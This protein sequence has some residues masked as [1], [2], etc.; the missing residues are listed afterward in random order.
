MMTGGCSTVGDAVFVDLGQGRNLIGLVAH[1]DIA[2]RA[3]DYAEVP[4]DRSGQM[5]ASWYSYAARWRGARILTGKN[6]PALVT[7]LDLNDPATGRIV[8][9]TDADFNSVFGPDYRL[10]SIALEI[11]P[12]GLWPFNLVGLWGT[13]VSRGIKKHITWMDDPAVIDSPGW[14]RL[15]AGARNVIEG[16]RRPYRS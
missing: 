1:D 16:L 13:P 4:R 7:F 8:P 12:V 15:P 3:F 2:A 11:V 5:L 10:A 14:M 9:A 6:I